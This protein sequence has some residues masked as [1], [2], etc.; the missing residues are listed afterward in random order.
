MTR[1][2]GSDPNCYVAGHTA[3]CSVFSLG[4][5]VASVCT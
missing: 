3:V 1:I 5:G 4:G 2:K